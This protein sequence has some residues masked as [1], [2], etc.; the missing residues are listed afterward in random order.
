M[1][2]EFAVPPNVRRLPGMPAAMR[3]IARLDS[4]DV[5]LGTC[6]H[7]YIARCWAQVGRAR[8]KFEAHGAPS[9]VAAVEALADVLEAERRAARR[10]R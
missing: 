6:E 1:P 5:D 8:K 2:G 10:K 4:S 3:R 7:G 9:P